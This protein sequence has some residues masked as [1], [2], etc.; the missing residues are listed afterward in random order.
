MMSA[1]PFMPKKTHSTKIYISVR[2][3]KVPETAEAMVEAL[4][5]VAFGSDEEVR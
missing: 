1:A 5:Q 2:I 3:S 4:R